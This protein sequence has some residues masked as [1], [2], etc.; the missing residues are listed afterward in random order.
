MQNRSNNV[1]RFSRFYIDFHEKLFNVHVKCMRLLSAAV[2]F[3]KL[4]RIDVSARLSQRKPILHEALFQNIDE[5][6]IDQLFDLVF[7]VFREFAYWR[8]EELLRLRELNDR[9]RFSLKKFIIALLSNDAAT[10]SSF[11][12]DYDIS[13]Q[14]TKI[15]TE[16]VSAPFFELSAETFSH[17]IE[18]SHWNEAICPVCGSQPAFSEIDEQREIRT[19]WCRRCNTTWH[20]SVDKC[21]FCL[22]DD[23]QKQKLLFLSDRKPYRVEACDQCG[24]YLKTV[25]HS[26][27]T[28]KIDFSVTNIATYYLD[29]LAKHLGYE[30][31]DYLSFYFELSN[32]DNSS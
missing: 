20:Y 18:Q 27:L 31:N 7:P 25:N 4:N 2:S 22:N 14:F 13:V 30:L 19:L 1:Q 10:F 29:I 12:K 21:P 28:N 23:P 32:H 26:F 24:Q 16:L 6:A 11:S 9:R 15:F 8:K 17:R 3:Q 5:G